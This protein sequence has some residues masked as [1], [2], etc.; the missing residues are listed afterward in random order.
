AGG[1]TF[2]GT[3]VDAGNPSANAVYV[4]WGTDTNA[5]AKTNGWT[6]GGCGGTAADGPRRCGCHAE[7][8]G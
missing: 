3:L 2:N 1:A 4:L 6:G 7:A 8:G 5:W